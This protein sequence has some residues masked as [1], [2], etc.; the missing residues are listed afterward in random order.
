MDVRKESDR[1]KECTR[2]EVRGGEEQRYAG[3]CVE[4]YNKGR[5]V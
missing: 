3:G 5:R 2:E 4:G 1:L